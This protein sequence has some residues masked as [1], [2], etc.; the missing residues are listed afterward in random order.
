VNG[1]MAASG[2]SASAVSSDAVRHCLDSDVA[3]RSDNLAR[4]NR[5]CHNACHN[6]CNNGGALPPAKPSK[7][8]GFM[9]LQNGSLS[10]I[11]TYGHSINSRV[12]FLIF[13][14]VLSHVRALP[15]HGYLRRSRVCHNA[16]TCAAGN[17]IRR[18]RAP[19]TSGAGEKICGLV[20]SRSGG[21]GTYR[22]DALVARSAAGI[23]PPSIPPRA[24][25]WAA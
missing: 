15:P 17:Q 10:R 21:P 7:K 13:Q 18:M 11:R 24:Q 6:K 20:S 25:G 1:S 14:R 8:R 9:R 12:V 4:T 23:I 22:T 19:A 2:A 5:E 3:N 16:A